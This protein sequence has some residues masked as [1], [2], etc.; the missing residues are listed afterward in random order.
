MT[1]FAAHILIAMS[2]TSEPD[3]PFTVWENV[4]LLE[5]GDAAAA[6][7]MAQARGRADASAD[8]S[9]TVDDQPA[10]SQFAGVRKLINISNPE[11]LD[12]D[13]DR[14]VSGTEITYSEFLVEGRDGLAKLADGESVVVDYVD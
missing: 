4:V 10:R 1:W 9:L 3:G 11:P 12:P 13:G 14:P 5:A 8:D 2:K 7:E 6:L